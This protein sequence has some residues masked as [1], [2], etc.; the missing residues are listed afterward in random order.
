MNPDAIGDLSSQMQGSRL[1]PL[2]ALRCFEAAARL[3]SFSRAADE[4]HLTHGAVSRAVR[5][6]ELDLGVTLFERR[7]RRVFLTAA[8]ARLRDAVAEAFATIAT[9]TRE[10]RRRSGPASPLVLSCEP[11]LLM[12]WLIPRLPAFQ[13][14]HPEVNLHFAAGGGPVAFAQEGIHLAIRRDDFPFPAGVQAELIMAERVGPVCSPAVASGLNARDGA[15]GKLSN[16]TL[17]HTR[18]RPDAWSRW[19]ELSG[20]AVPAGH[21]ELWFEHF[22]F[23]LQAAAA[24]LGVAIGPLALVQQDVEAGALVAPFG[25]VSDN[26]AYYLLSPDS[27]SGDRRAETLLLWLR[28]QAASAASPIRPPHRSRGSRL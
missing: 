28:A 11:T 26:S 6:L 13:A 27:I 5:A 23:S 18:T 14:E 21:R 12:R 16:A 15:A 24:G 10:L 3:E 7:S 4:L 17:L 8:G 20:T 25:F 22:Y 1:P 2:G 19:A 9:V